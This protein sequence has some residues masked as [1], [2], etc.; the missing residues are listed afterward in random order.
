MSPAPAAH[1][2]VGLPAM[3]DGTSLAP[4]LLAADQARLGE[5]VREAEEAGARWLHVDVMDGHFVPNL[6]LGVPA[7]HSLRRVT[8]AFLDVHLMIERPAAF[9][10]PFARAGADLITV[11]LEASVH[12]HRDLHE[13]RRLGCRAGVAINPSTPAEALREVV[14]FADLVLVMTVNPGFGGQAFIHS[15]L[16]KVTAVRRMAAELGLRKLHVQVDGGVDAETAPAC[17]QAGATCLVAGTSVF[18]GEGS[19]A[20]NL[21]ALRKAIAVPV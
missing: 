20:E 8:D 14:A 3:P 7:V 9:L 2:G 13:I 17:A 5:L 10:E 15:S 6:A 1:E 19:V 16:R 12:L 11:H 18:G 21:T 4:S